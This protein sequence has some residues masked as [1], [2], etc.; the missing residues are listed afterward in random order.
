MYIAEEFC[1]FMSLNLS[2]AQIKNIYGD[3]VK[4]SLQKFISLEIK[5]WRVNFI[6]STTTTVGCFQDHKTFITYLICMY[7]LLGVY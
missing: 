6:D 4:F 3:L 2:L 1:I 5:I 7:N